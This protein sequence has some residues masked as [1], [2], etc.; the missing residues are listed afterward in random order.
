MRATA[1]DGNGSVT[2]RTMTKGDDLLARI[3]ADPDDDSTYL[4]YADW[5][6]TTGDPVGELIVVM[7]QL[8]AA[9]AADDDVRRAQLGSVLDGYVTK[10]R[11]KLFGTLGN[12]AGIAWDFKFGLLRSVRVVP[13]VQ[14]D[15]A[16]LITKILALPISRV[17]R[18]LVVFEDFTHHDPGIAAAVRANAPK[19]LPGVTF[20]Q[21]YESLTDVDPVDVRWFEMQFGP[22]IPDEILALPN[23]E[24]LELSRTNV[25]EISPRIAEL[26]KLRRLD[27]SWC[28]ELESLPEELFGIE[29]LSYIQMYDCLGLRTAYHMGRVNHLLGGFTRAHTPSRRRIIETNLFL[30]NHR[31]A[32][33]LASTEDLLAALDNN[34]GVVRETALR[35][36]A[37]RLPDPALA[38][39]ASFALVGK[40]NYTKNRIAEGVAAHGAKLTAKVTDATTHVI[41]G[42]EPG[43]KQLGIGTRPVVLETHLKAW[44]EPASAEQPRELGSIRD[45]LRSRDDAATARALATLGES[46]PDE[47]LTE[48][49]V[50]AIDIKLKK[51]REAA[52]KL[53]ALGAPASVNAAIKTHLKQS[54]LLES[55]GETKR[56]DRIVAFCRAAKVIDPLELAVALGY[57]A[58]VGLGYLFANGTGA[59]VSRALEGRVV[60]GVLDLS[61]A[62]IA[63]LPAQVGALAKVVE[64][65]LSNNH[66]RT[67]P[68]ALHDMKSLARLDL[69]GNQLSKIPAAAGKLRLTK[70]ALGHNRFSAFPMPVLEMSTLRHLDIS[71]EQYVE[72]EVRIAGIPDEIGGLTELETFAYRYQIIERLP[73]SLFTLRKLTELDLMTCTLPAEIPRQFAELT[74]LRT[75]ELSYSTWASRAAELRRL[76]PECA[77]SATR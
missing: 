47:L 75:L 59:D 30:G 13:D 33:E 12:H 45:A 48:V 21:K 69:S 27:I 31:R 38:T 62:E 73:D 5:L 52:K 54:L 41:V 46:I 65:D 17:L 24:C 2:V 20:A 36:L 70:L 53:L 29:T 50:I 56:S 51:A 4:V 76:L 18:E 23:L 44:F 40:T 42:E 19:T 39:A 8:A 22:Q 72:R 1:G 37:Q 28:N 3:I 55:M 6:E 9:E 16:E 63:E 60:D 71:S 14:E 68:D 32:L 77:I 43:G 61:V 7:H 74:S 57:R 11:S 10:H 34:V 66:L 15:R 49:V 25:T 67:W 26:V 35:C 58:R 64:L